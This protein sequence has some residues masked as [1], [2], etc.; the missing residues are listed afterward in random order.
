[1]LELDQVDIVEVDIF[2]DDFM[3]DPARAWSRAAEQSWLAK[4]AFGYAVL[5]YDAMREIESDPRLR[6]PNRDI[7][8]MMGG[9]PGTPFERFTGHFMLALDGAEHQRMRKL[10]APAFTPKAANN[11]RQLMRETI[12]RVLD[13][14]AD[15]G[16]CDFSKVVERYPISVMCEMLGLR[17]SD[18]PSIKNYLEH[19]GVTFSLDPAMVPLANEILGPLFD[20]ATNVIEERR[21][22]GE[23][24]QDLV[25]S[26]C[27][28]AD[29]RDRFSEEELKVLIV[30][31]LSAGY[32]TTKNQLT[33]IMKL[34]CDFPEEYKKLAADPKRLKPFIEESLRF[35]NPIAGSW[36]FVN[37]DMEYRGVRFPADTMIMIPLGYAGR[38]GKK[39]ADPN[40]FDPDRSG[41]SHL[42]FGSGPHICVGMFLARAL[43]EEA[44]PIIVRRLAHPRQTGPIAHGEVF[45]PIWLCRS[46]PIA[47]DPERRAAS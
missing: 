42:T 46:L 41:K 17:A 1:M 40:R 16:E 24:P 27:D 6:T 13:E 39:N 33:Y 3:D 37:E 11:Y 22:P 25:Q 23:H 44:V 21:C 29:S 31:L 7:V 10:V 2:N 20:Y 4:T 9:V 30:F 15:K 38:D 35:L 12:E 5:D 34:L 28:L 36:R 45:G 19:M 47:F 18:I 8:K 14:V 32:D 43:M 26:L